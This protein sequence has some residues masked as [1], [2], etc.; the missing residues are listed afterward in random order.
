MQI[1]MDPGCIAA[2]IVL[3]DAVRLVPI[4]LRGPPEPGQR[5]GKIRRRRCAREAGFEID[6]VHHHLDGVNRP[7]ACSITLA[8]REQR[9]FIKRPADQ[10]QAERQSLRVLARGYRNA[11]QPRHVHGDGEDVV[12]IHL[13]RIG[14]TFLA[15]AKR[16]RRR[17]RCQHRVHALGETI[18]EVFLD[19]G[20]HLLRPQIISIVIAGRKHIGA[21]HDAAANL[22][23]KAFGA[24]VLIH[25]ADRA[26][27]DPQ[28]V[29]HAV[30]AREVRRGFRGCDDVIG[31]QRVFGVRQR[32]LDQFG[33]G[34]LQPIAAFGP[35]LLDLRRHAVEAILLGDTDLH[36]LDRSADR[37]LVV[38]HLAVDRGGVPSDHGRPSSA[39]GSQCRARCGPIGP[40]WSS[41][42]AKATVPQRE[43][44][45]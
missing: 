10:L 27:V 20:A 41:E 18:L 8:D 31:R 11:R 33:T 2:C 35:K 28:A 17:R 22:G 34:R 9:L 14:A 44:R 7:A 40:A 15:D 29:A 24:G 23:A 21:D 19:Q 38:R 26:A 25:L 6:R 12:Q 39:A 5:R 30:I 36:A 3:D 13:D 16:R 1:G 43:Q 4:A 32:H 45:P 37:G 42:D